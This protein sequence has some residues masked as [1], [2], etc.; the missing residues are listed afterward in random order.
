MTE[1]LSAKDAAKRLHTTCG[2]LAVWRCTRRKKLA[3]VK[4]GGGRIFYRPDDIEAFIAESVQPG[5]GPRSAKAKEKIERRG[6]HPL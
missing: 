2:T 3:F 5:D 6:K 1:L 4:L